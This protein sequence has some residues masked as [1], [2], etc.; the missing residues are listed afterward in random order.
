M[1]PPIGQY[2]HDGVLGVCA[3]TFDGID[4]GL[5]VD[6]ISI[7]YM[8]NTKDIF[9]A[10]RG[11]MADDKIPTGQAYQVKIKFGQLNNARMAKLYRGVELSDTGK[12]IKHGRNIYTSGKTNFAKELILTRVDSDG[13]PSTDLFFRATFFK[14]MPLEIGPEIFGPD[15]QRTQEVTFYCFYDDVKQCYYVAG[16]PSSLGL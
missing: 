6:E 1:N 4:M 14:A 13:N 15:S 5:S 7:E 11:T 2:F 16:Y 9:F 8:E 3:V 12:S 10:S